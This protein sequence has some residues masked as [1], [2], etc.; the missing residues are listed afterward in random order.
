[1]AHEDFWV[2]E[3]NTRPYL[4]AILKDEDDAVIPLTLPPNDVL[5]SMEDRDTGAAKISRQSC[6]ITD[7]ANGVVQYRWSSGDTDTPGVY[8]GEFII[9]W[10][11]AGDEIT[12]PNDG[13]IVIVVKAKVE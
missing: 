3:D 9:D 11:G 4:E 7:A 12:C 6:V 8:F 2:K 10:D 5:F 13:Y 1:M